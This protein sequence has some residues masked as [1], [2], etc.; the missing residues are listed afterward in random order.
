MRTLA[1]LAGVEAL[2]L[3]GGESTAVGHGLV[4]AGLGPLGYE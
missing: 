3:P 4:D 2:I 1:V